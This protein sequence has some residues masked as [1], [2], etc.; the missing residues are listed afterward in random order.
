MPANV[1]TTAL[2][3]VVYT[4]PAC[5]PLARLAANEVVRRFRVWDRLVAGYP[6]KDG[7]QCASGAEERLATQDDAAPAPQGNVA[8]VVPLAQGNPAVPSAG[9]TGTSGASP[10][11]AGGV[12]RRLL[13]RWLR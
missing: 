7:A 12:V 4:T 6:A 1:A 5:N 11:A 13:G 3:V 8:V 2:G 10:A 9:P